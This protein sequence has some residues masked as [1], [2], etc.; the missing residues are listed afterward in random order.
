VSSFDGKLEYTI[1]PLPTLWQIFIEQTYLYKIAKSIFHS[2]LSDNKMYNKSQYV[3]AL[4]AIWWLVR[5]DI[6]MRI[7]GFDTNFFLYFEDVDLCRRIKK[8]GYL[9]RYDH[10]GSI[11]H[12]GHQSFGGITNGQLYTESLHNYLNKYHNKFYTFL[13][14]FIF[15]CGCLTRLLYWKIKIKL[16]HNDETVTTGNGKIIFF[17]SVIKYYSQLRIKYRKQIYITILFLICELVLLVLVAILAIKIKSFASTKVKGTQY[18]TIINREN[19]IFSGKEGEL[20]YFYEPKP[21]LVEK[22]HPDWLGYEVVYTI[23]SDS[24]NE[25]SEY[26]FGKNQN[27]FRIITL[28]DSHTFG[29]YVNTQEN[30]PE[31]LEELLNSRLHCVN[32]KR[33]EVI[34]LGVYN[35]D[36][37]Y[38]VYRFRKRGLKYNPDL[39]IWL[40]NNWN[41]EKIDEYY[42]PRSWEL[43]KEKEIAFNPKTKGFPIYEIIKKEMFNN[44]GKESIINYQFKALSNISSIYKGKI[45]FLS[46]QN[47]LPLY[48]SLVAR[49]LTNNKLSS[50]YELPDDLNNYK[51]LDGHPSVLGYKI[52]AE[53]ILNLLQK[54][55]L[56][57]CYL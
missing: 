42:I 4:A 21:N 48:K 3:C 32:K 28:G 19:L 39:V 33:F 38:S 36:I 1:L 52:M 23:N 57:E 44:F 37:E 29:Q 22:S 2:P 40:I 47:L 25:S 26:T 6:F 53:Y 27:S 18:A 10:T 46:Y 14:L 49:I 24:L 54:N 34:N 55:I 51:L 17:K 7:G 30:Y 56:S 35:Y 12:I 43:V 15:I 16:V 50:Y 20:K 11:Y 31:Q 8:E 5:K 13:Y 41:F 9:I 45:M